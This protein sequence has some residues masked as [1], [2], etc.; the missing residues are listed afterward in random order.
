MITIDDM[1]TQVRATL[2]RVDDQYDV[3]AIAEKI[4]TAYGLVDISKVPGE[5]YWEIVAQHDK[6]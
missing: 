2:D 1:K 4:Q 3:E 6:S 5:V